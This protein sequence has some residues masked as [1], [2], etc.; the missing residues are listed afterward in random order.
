MKLLP[1]L[2]ADYQTHFGSKLSLPEYR[3]IE[4]YTK[5]KKLAFADPLPPTDPFVAAALGPNIAFML[6]ESHFQAEN[7]ALESAGTWATYLA[8]PRQTTSQKIV[9]EIYRILRIYHIAST[10]K[11]GHVDIEDGII[12]T[13]CSFDRVA[14]VLSISTTGLGLLQ[15]FVHYYL[16]SLNQPYSDAYNDLIIQQYFADIVVEIKRFNDVD[17]V[18]YQFH[19]KL[20]FNRHFRYDCDNPKFE[21]TETHCK[22]EIGPMYRNPA[23]YP[24]DFFLEMT[25]KMYI[26]PV[27]ALIDG[28]IALDQLPKWEAKIP[29]ATLP[30]SFRSRFGREVM[31]PGLPMT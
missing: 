6:L 30:A 26:I 25:G 5:K 11:N 10:Q 19:K 29:N 22:F 21:I 20:Y 7:P 23:I 15:S 16:N 4:L 14:L 31:I 2:L 27:E 13:Y 12:R 28:D 3:Q 8:V 9:A 1:E 17:R 24:I 18:L